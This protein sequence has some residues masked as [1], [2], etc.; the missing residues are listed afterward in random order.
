MRIGVLMWAAASLVF[1]L[2]AA[3]V[4]SIV[5]TVTARQRAQAARSPWP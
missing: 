5:L 4:V 2:A 3:L 1:L